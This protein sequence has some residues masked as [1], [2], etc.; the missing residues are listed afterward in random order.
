MIKL[1]QIICY[2]V[3]S[4][5]RCYLSMFSRRLFL[6]QLLLFLGA[7]QSTETNQFGRLTLGA[8]SYGEDQRP[9]EQY[10]DLIDYL[11]AE[12]K[13]IIEFEPTFNEIRAM[14]Q[15]QRGIWS[16]VFA[17]PGLAALAI[18]EA[19]YVPLFPLEGVEN[20]RFLIIVRQESAIQKLTELQGKAIALGQPGSAAGYYLP[21]Y[22]LYGL[23]LSEIRLASTP[24]T[25]LQ[26]I[27]QQEVVAG[28]LSL[29]DFERYRSNFKQ[30]EFR[31]IFSG[32]VPPGAILVAPTVELYQQE[33]IRKILASASPR[34][35][36]EAGYLPNA[37]LPNY[38]G[39]IELITK[40]KPLDEKLKKKPVDL[41]Q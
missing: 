23:T 38:R 18:F 33:Q 40:V 15:I 17:P 9:T 36:A 26:W 34:I 4:K 27:D 22:H 28:A 24:K 19:Q 14:E 39:L 35:I 5:N 16:L 11:E 12:L 21:L 1:M 31:V 37:Q 6:W 8:V 32:S 30:T 41:H 25:I 3:T 10:A 29:A 13:T 20:T 7:C 2:I